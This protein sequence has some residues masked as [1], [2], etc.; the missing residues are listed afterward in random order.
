MAKHVLAQLLERGISQSRVLECAR[1]G[2]C[3]QAY[4]DDTPFPSALV[5][6]MADNEPLHVVAAFDE[7]AKKVY[8]IT[9]Y[10]PSSDIF[11]SDFITRKKK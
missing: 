9:A 5:F 3:I 8:I 11:E 1:L 6:A 7:E 4:S 2:V 10:T